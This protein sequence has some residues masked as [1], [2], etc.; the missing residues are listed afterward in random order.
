MDGSFSNLVEIQKYQKACLQTIALKTAPFLVF[1]CLDT[2]VFLKMSPLKGCKPVTETLLDTLMGVS[3]VLTLVTG[4]WSIK[5]IIFLII[6][7]QYFYYYLR[8]TLN[9]F[10][11]NT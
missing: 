1:D 2:S 10:Y 9:Y 8:F 3:V 7:H 4:Q 11:H 6:K 5:S